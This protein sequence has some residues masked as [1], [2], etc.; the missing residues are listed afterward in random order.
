MAD[1]SFLEDAGSQP[2][3]VPLKVT[4]DDPLKEME[5]S[6]SE[7]ESRHKEALASVKSPEDGAKIITLSRVLDSVPEVVKS[8]MADA[9]LEAKTP[10]YSFFKEFEK[11]NPGTAK[12]L[13]NN[14]VIAAATD[15]YDNMGAAEAL[16]R[17]TT[18]AWTQG[19]DSVNLSVLATRQASEA[20]KTGKASDLYEAEIQRLKAKTEAIKN[21]EGFH[22][23]FYGAQQLPNMIH[24]GKGYVKNF[25]TGTG[26][27]AAAGVPLRAASLPFPGAN[28]AVNAALTFSAPV[29]GHYW[30]LKGAADRTRELEAGQ[31]YLDYRDLVDENG[32]R[33]DPVTAARNALNEGT[34]NAGFELAGDYA[35]AMMFGPAAS[36]IS[37]MGKK[38][39]LKSAEKEVAEIFA[40]KTLMQALKSTAARVGTG[41]GSEVLT[42]SAQQATQVGFREAAKAQSGGSYAPFD[43]DAAAQEVAS[44]WGPTIQAT[45][46]L[47]LAG[48]GSN[49]MSDVYQIQQAEKAQ[50]FYEAFGDTVAASKLR[51][52]LPQDHRDLI[53]E[54]TKDSP[55]ENVYIPVEAMETYYQSKGID[56]NAAIKE[57]GIE[58]QYA[59]AKET[60][61]DV[62]VPLG[63]WAEKVA[64]TEHYKG[65]VNDIKFD[66]EGYTNNQKTEALARIE[67]EMTDLQAKVESEIKTDVIKQAGFDL[68][69]KSEK[70]KLLKLQK[71]FGM[72]Q[73]SW[74]RKADAAA[75]IAASHAVAESARQGKTV[76][77][78]YS[79]INNPVVSGNI[80]KT[81]ESFAA[82]V[83]DNSIGY[84]IYIP[85]DSRGD[86]ADLIKQYPGMFTHQKT[87]N[88]V[89]QASA[90][91]V[92]DE[93]QFREALRTDRK[94]SPE[95]EQL[96]M[97]E[98]ARNQALGQLYLELA[99]ISEE[100]LQELLANPEGLKSFEKA[101]YDQ[102][103]V[104]DMVNRI[105]VK[106]ANNEPLFQ[107]MPYKPQLV[108][109][110]NINAESLRDADAIG[111]IAVPSMAVT[112]YGIPFDDFG[113]ITLIGH[114]GLADPSKVPVFSSDAYSPRFPDVIWK[115]VKI[116]EARTFQAE[117]NPYFKKA[118]DQAHMVWDYMVNNPD[119]NKAIWEMEK[120][121]GA[122]LMYIEKIKKQSV[123]NI[124][125]RD[126]YLYGGDILKDQAVQDL[127]KSDPEMA[128]NAYHLD[129]PEQNAFY[130]LMT[131]TVK[132][133][134]ERM[135]GSDTVLKDSYM[136]R[137]FD[138]NG[139][140]NFGTYDSIVRDITQGNVGKKEV[141][142]YALNEMLDNMIIAA[143]G[144]KHAFDKW[145]FDTISGLFEG[146]R[147]KVK[148]RLVPLTLENAVEAMA[149]PKVKAREKSMTFS[150]GKLQ[151][152]ISQRFKTIEQLRNEADRLVARSDK[153]ED[154]YKQQR[155][156]E[157][158][159][160][161]KALLY[162]TIKNYKGEVDTW[163]G[164]DASMKALA[165][166]AKTG[167][168][169]S[170][171]IRALRQN[172]F[173]GFED[174]SHLL[175]L[176]TKIIQELKQI[177]VDYFE[178]KPQRAVKLDEFK[179]AVIGPHQPPFVMEILQKHGI[180]YEIHDGTTKGRA[181]TTKNL[182]RKL[183]KSDDN[184][185]FQKAKKDI[186]NS[187]EFKKWFAGSK[188][189]DKNGKPLVV[190][191][192][193]NEPFTEMDKFAG[194]YLFFSENKA[195]AKGFG[196]TTM[197]VYLSAKKLFDYKDPASIE[198]VRP[199]VKKHIGR[200][201]DP[202]SEDEMWK[203]N[204]LKSIMESYHDG[205]NFA[206]IEQVDGFIDELKRLGFDGFTTDEGGRN[207]AVFNSS[208]IKSI[209]NKGSFDSLN[210]DIYYQTA[211]HGSGVDHNRFSTQYIG[212]GEGAQVKGWG[213]Y[214]ADEKGVAEYY[215][216]TLS[217]ERMYSGDQ[218]VKLNDYVKEY[219][220]KNKTDI[221]LAKAKEILKA[222]GKVFLENGGAITDISKLKLLSKDQKLYENKDFINEMYIA[223]RVK[224]LL[225]QYTKYEGYD[226]GEAIAAFENDFGKDPAGYDAIQRITKDM[227][228]EHNDISFK[229]GGVLYK[230]DLSPKDNE[231]LD[232]DKPLA[233]QEKN[234]LK[235][236]IEKGNVGP[237]TKLFIDEL[238]RI[239]DIA[240][241]LKYKKIDDESGYYIYNSETYKN[242]G[243]EVKAG[244]VLG[245]GKTKKEAYAAFIENQQTLK[246]QIY[247]TALARDLA[248]NPSEINLTEGAFYN[249]T[250]DGKV[251][252][253]EG[254]SKYLL[255]MG[256]KGIKYYDQQSRGKGQ[257][258]RN[259]VIFDDSHV[260][261]QEKYYQTP[262]PAMNPVPTFYTKAERLIQD[263]PNNILGKND[264]AGILKQLKG[265]ERKWS[266][267]DA[268]L[269]G[270]EKVSKQELLD[271][272]KGNEVEVQ[273]VIKGDISGENEMDAI[274]AEKALNEG[275]EVYALYDDGTEGLIEKASDL[276][277]SDRFTLGESFKDVA[278]MNATKFPTFQIAGGKNYREL[279]FILPG[280]KEIYKSP[281]YSEDN[282]FAH[283]RFNERT[284]SK[285]RRVLF[286]EEIQS[287]LHQ[288]G[289]KEGYRVGEI[290]ELPKDY[291]I[292]QSEGEYRVH[293]P[294]IENG[295]DNSL[296]SIG[297]TR[298]E[299]I[300][301]AITIL[302]RRE[303]DG[304]Y[305]KG[306]PDYPFKKTWHE[307]ALKR[308]V[309]WAAE[310]GFDEIAWTTG[311]QQA[312]RYPREEG[313]PEKVAQEKG[314][315]GFYDKIIP[316]YLNSFGKKFDVKVENITINNDL[317]F[318]LKQYQDIMNDPE[319]FNK[320]TPEEKKSFLHEMNALSLA[321]KTEQ[322]S[323][324]ITE[325]MKK[326]ALEEGFT[327]Y[328]G[329]EVN[330]DNF[331]TKIGQQMAVAYKSIL[332]WQ[333]GRTVFNEKKLEKDLRNNVLD[334]VKLIR[335]MLSDKAVV[336]LAKKD[337][338]VDTGIE[339]INEDI[340]DLVR[341]IDKWPA[342][343]ITVWMSQIKGDL[344]G[345]IG[346][347]PE[348]SSLMG[349]PWTE[350]NALSNIDNTLLQGTDEAAKGQ[351]E[352]G[353]NKAVI[354]LF[355]HADAS[356]YI[357]ESSHIWLKDMWDFVNS[358]QANE[359]Y[360]KDWDVVKKWLDIKES[361]EKLTR[362]QH[363]K[364][365][366]GFEA[367]LMEGKA[368]SEGLRSVFNNL[369]NWLTQ[370]YKDIRGL[371]VY[372]TD[373]VRGVMDRMLA[374]DEE[375]AY[376]EKKSG[377]A[378]GKLTEGLDPEVAAQIK[379]LQEKAHERAV[380]S[381][382]TR[383]MEEL[384]PE[385][386]DA[387]DAERVRLT[388][389]ISEQLG[390]QPEYQAQMAIRET[391]RKDGKEMS[392]K[393]REG[394]LTAEGQMKYDLLAEQLGFSSGDEM[395]QKILAAPEYGRTVRDLVNK[396]M[397]NFDTLHLTAEMR[398]EA[399]MAIHNDKQLELLA[400]E[401]RELQKLLEVASNKAGREAVRNVGLEVE[402]IKLQASQILE[403]KDLV[404][405]S[406]YL[407]YFTA[408]R[409]AAI[410]V[411]K[412]LANRD[413]ATAVEAKRVQLMNHALAIAAIKNKRFVDKAAAQI[414]KVFK[415]KMDLF[416]DQSSFAQAAS[417]LSRF[418]LGDRKD[419]NISMKTETLDQWSKKMDNL[420][421]GEEGSGIVEIA[422]WIKDESKVINFRRLTVEQF[423]DVRNA[424]KNI[425]RVANK[426]D[427]FY[428]QQDAE[429]IQDAAQQLVEELDKNIGSKIKHT[430]EP[431]RFDI[432]KSKLADYLWSLERMDTTVMRADGWKEFGKWWSFLK[433]PVA[434]AANNESRMIHE[435]IDKLKE[436]WKVYSKKEINDIF[437]KKMYIE[438]F[439]AS[440]TKQRLLAMAL[441]L[442]NAQN[443][444]KLFNNAPVGIEPRFPWTPDNA[445]ITEK[446]VMAILNDHLS[447][448]D[449]KF[450]QGIWDHLDS[451]WPKIAEVNRD[452]T[453]FEPGR[454]E[455]VP[456]Q[457]VG[458]DGVTVDMK[459]GYY[460]L[461][462]DFRATERAAMREM[463]GEPLYTE[464]NPAY[465][466][467]TKTGHT[468]AR[469][470]A[471]YSLTLDLDLINRHLNDVIH[472]INF[473]PVVYDL[474]RLIANKTMEA[475]IRR[476]MGDEGYRN[477][478]QWVKSVATGGNVDKLG[479]D[480]LSWFARFLNNK[481]T[482]AI[483]IGR[484]SIIMN[485]LA[486]PILAINKVQGFGSMDV[487]KGMLM[488]GSDYWV[489]S[490]FNWKA[491]KEIRDFV[492][493][494]STFMRDKREVPDFTLQDFK[495]TK[496]AKDP[497]LQ[498]FFLQM[499]A[500]T[501]DLTNIPMWLE[502]YNKKLNE[503]Q[504][505][506]E[507]IR[508]A[509]TL[510]DRI[511][512]SGR[513]YDQAK[514]LRGTDIE[515][516]LSKLYSFWNVEY[517]NWIKEVS[518]EKR[519]M[520]GNTPRF[521]GFL[522]SRVMFLA[523]S[524][525][526]AQQLPRDDDDPVAWW[527]AAVF[528]YPMS[529]FPGAREV[530]TLAVKKALDLPTF[531]YRVAPL[532]SAIEGVGDIGKYVGDFISGDGDL[533]QLLE[534]GTK[535]AAYATGYSDQFNSWFWNAFDYV[536][537][538]MT[539]ELGD[540]YRRRRKKD[541]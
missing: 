443:R 254:A 24:A 191:H 139:L 143:D 355:S 99:G 165:D 122:K 320:M 502:A 138:E 263:N 461:K 74:D 421:Q 341:H 232:L 457:V 43:L 532:A 437:N 164:M 70:E 32:N 276:Q 488:R 257:G 104:V 57:L 407:P 175:A 330:P 469:T 322:P 115:P 396:S 244:T 474:R 30:G 253:P 163:A 393:Y 167:G 376:A 180:P 67:K 238:N 171:V 256:I 28:V 131:D 2:L 458:N 438:E 109:L 359:A 291:Q 140:L 61:G 172:G 27:A 495:G 73:K 251:I 228:E 117:I 499:I 193:T 96:A 430:V 69:Y 239:L 397:A 478:N 459:G 358:G 425:V 525:L 89:S 108:A 231:Y 98:D 182:I 534:A 497:G 403:G 247:Y 399:E 126:V 220:T 311:K 60:G 383:T 379:D 335:T 241:N 511:T 520:I 329:L 148:G 316:D 318:Q 246:P 299:A 313:T 471:Q 226:R 269:V 306:V 64:G 460:P 107:D 33:M 464:N 186:T 5:S 528:T 292:F 426:V 503:T 56:I 515:K 308:M 58:E 233:L 63:T 447:S 111:G 4:N 23:L 482:M 296:V 204:T 370:I 205:V 176:S 212:S 103:D 59:S 540:L 444:M 100:T 325:E 234:I 453:G 84:P 113:D 513:K 229:T 116:K 501:D 529:F 432:G 367:Y 97:E 384:H 302:N 197:P 185:L 446:M 475:G 360:L 371:N 504:N 17:Q 106:K 428:T 476:N 119:R 38:I 206:F 87:K 440:V 147:I 39:L 400:I 435:S 508:Y 181:K 47:G 146:P 442:G 42:E 423:N 419:Y 207:Y 152:V 516:L 523:L 307:L 537:N 16:I 279:L 274:Q 76:Q 342:D 8:N 533:Q 213:L 531:G 179:G 372:I 303:S 285:G 300:S 144:N 321:E 91:E 348:F 128:R 498:E 124:P 470:A 368:P 252:N 184:I 468:K 200:Y 262:V 202:F 429:S 13:K 95:V 287:D 389:E 37:G 222:G 521:L 481:T 242:R 390:L 286:I 85:E 145:V 130:S 26:V 215:K 490:A 31:A 334:T 29:A 448:K 319:R 21:P 282:V 135:A 227:L 328:Q 49:I 375:I 216:E 350:F 48:G 324:P 133:A 127:V 65:L 527:L 315:A 149:S 160:R 66:P 506:E 466:A 214:F 418:G 225:K 280:M 338:Y 363:E 158:I 493:S 183:A 343:E 112:K 398:Q 199:W 391:F 45:L 190:Y 449:W 267:I 156:R 134:I 268:F 347:H 170:S 71:P 417:I 524:N 20:V 235:A 36:T 9:E 54:I 162:F 366:R 340:N 452:I 454:V 401:G 264:L 507:A 473:R 489:K 75:K 414:H 530:G 314:M 40:K 301:N 34:V 102:D 245:H 416:K 386:K 105:L 289:R 433:R 208:Q 189:V 526:I 415:R 496:I 93:S 422:D 536:V 155:E 354:T 209:S 53:N 132:A 151:A 77:E 365:A 217:E 539:P 512:G 290:K 352:F 298:E 353:R 408:E 477:I 424:L 312:E 18:D 224:D 480:A 484:T 219:I 310:N 517:N 249:T 79:G 369:R 382:L 62:K 465:K 326:S 41:I 388:K 462:E 72:S 362:E 120:S 412:A 431:G 394:Q 169:K 361:Q 436:I 50:K 195:F 110:H 271:F 420:F 406:T 210:P 387:R 187:P 519:D 451:Y 472:D 201:N 14:D 78:W 123:D 293:T 492:H 237:E 265:E 509:D 538:G 288:T 129:T 333:L 277:N 522:A 101:G 223:D 487:L 284:D 46:L 12:Y 278:G 260:T 541:R 218:E 413:Y 121:E 221:T 494:K 159:Y 236:I 250:Q 381:L 427:K 25:L 483:V 192:G 364:F 356:T 514:I 331:A 357:H 168:G 211:W 81:Y 196:K 270:K 198:E 258:S 411:G 402:M 455:A 266:G 441:N 336:K 55:V 141:D 259:Y 157:E 243:Q 203:G 505:D 281:H 178:A 86:Y 467:A 273:E 174:D 90:D 125:L 373:D 378:E 380:Q 317:G 240:K 374:T 535:T 188:V 255:S 510:I 463:S 3:F 344:H 294:S 10:D 153:T 52:R 410:K 323:L 88:G 19:W 456:F 445:E 136:S 351:I 230:V 248:K 82:D 395:A 518:L 35:L 339:Q 11:K 261:I 272:L 94:Y 485:N 15:D 297:K 337:V 173:K 439:G 309:R 450:V 166:A 409:N 275:K 332:D 154:I 68:V 405:A 283:V 491:A 346:S 295:G 385:R 1:L 6:V 194:D 434:D 92:M 327:L 44:V 83:R 51:E 392:K 161:D 404:E 304:A 137:D 114:A 177:T 345:M 486:N 500:A 349:D 142:K 479:T 22:P 305:P 80:K 377:T 150:S 118:G 7:L